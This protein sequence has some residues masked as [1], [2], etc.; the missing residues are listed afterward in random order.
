MT[1][2]EAPGPAP[3]P[4]ARAALDALAAELRRVVAIADPAPEGWRSA[5]SAAYAWAA[6]DAAAAPLV[7]DS[8]AVRGGR[9]GTSH[10]TGATVREMRF[11]VGP[12]AVE[13]DVD[14]GADKVRVVGRV[15]PARAVEIAALW[16]EGRVATTSDDDGS[17]RFDEL[18]RRPLCLHVT[19]TP[20]VKTGW[21]VP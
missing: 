19:G 2:D 15:T 18:P 10:V 4:D 13:L 20:A 6:I 8:H 12:L 3:A 1:A 14:A 17:Y 7:Y 21:V 5:A 16:P 9:V 11:A